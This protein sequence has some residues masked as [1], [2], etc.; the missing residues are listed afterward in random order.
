MALAV[1][2]CVGV[3]Y[4]GVVWTLNPCV[5]PETIAAECAD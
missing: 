3:L 1:L 5:R 2:L 4:A